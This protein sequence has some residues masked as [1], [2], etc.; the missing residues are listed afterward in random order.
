MV[1]TSIIGNNDSTLK[2]CAVEIAKS[3]AEVINYD[4]IIT[5][6]KAII[7]GASNVKRMGTLHE[8]SLGVIATGR[9]KTTTRQ[10]AGS[11]KGTLPGVTY[12]ISSTSGTVVGTMAITGEAEKVRPFA[13]IVKKQ[14]EILLK[15]RELC[16]YA[17]NR[18]STLQNFIQDLSTF[19][20]GV[21]NEAMLLARACDFN[22][23]RTWYY[24]PVTIDLYQFGRFAISI[25]QDY[26]DGKGEKPETVI[27]NVRRRILLEIRRIFH[28]SRDISTVESNNHFIILH[29]LNSASTSLDIARI[30]SRIKERSH[31]LL[32]EIMKAGLNAA[33][34]IGSPA[35]GIAELSASYKEAWRA[36]MLGKKFK[37]G[38]GVYS[39]YDYRMEEMISTITA[40]VR[41]RFVISSTKLLRTQPDWE[42]LRDTI[43]EWCNSQFSLVK[44]AEL[45]HIHRNTLIYRLDKIHRISGLDMKDFRICLNLYMALLLE[46]YVGPGTKE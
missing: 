41:N 9:G 2:R 34:G 31:T 38:P 37:Q 8:A 6:T 39:I 10:E 24:I 1:M 46:Q 35:L 15:E 30:S 22:Y 11:M 33:I 44:T 29:A 4:V 17:V 7:V 20:P 32:D 43:K 23:D 12:P 28:D 25:R 42:E 40:P 3:T 19:V 26:I 36:L 14:I 21:S 27:Q 18:E 45:L 13:L 5:N 16:E